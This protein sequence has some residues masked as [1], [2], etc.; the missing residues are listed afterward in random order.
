MAG[1]NF[2]IAMQIRSGDSR[3]FQ[4]TFRESVQ[5]TEG[6]EVMTDHVD[7]AG[8]T[9][10]SFLEVIGIREDIYGEAIKK[11]IAWQLDEARNAAGMSKGALAKH[12]KTSRTQV[13]R[14]LDPTNVAV[15]L[16]TLD[17]AAQALGKRLEI[18]LVDPAGA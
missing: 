18:R 5:A 10:E 9:F 8:D 2:V 6:E 14:V 13:D 1:S 12:M 17:R 7:P 11:A 3:P 15:S 4:M 16:E